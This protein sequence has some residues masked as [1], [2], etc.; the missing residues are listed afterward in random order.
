VIKMAGRAITPVTPNDYFS[1]VQ[2]EQNDIIHLMDVWGSMGREYQDVF[3]RWCVGGVVTYWRMFDPDVEWGLADLSMF[4]HPL[5]GFGVGM[6]RGWTGNGYGAGPL[7]IPEQPVYYGSGDG[8]IVKD[9]LRLANKQ[10]DLI[11]KQI[12]MGELKDTYF[13]DA[14]MKHIGFERAT[15]M[16]YRDNNQTSS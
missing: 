7:E 3:G 1:L 11:E 9:L 12:V 5:I 15:S 6:Y 2:A 14:L 16:G 10:Q 4:A 13:L 8:A